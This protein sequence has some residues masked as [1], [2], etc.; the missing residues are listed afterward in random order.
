METFPP[1]PCFLLVQNR[2]PLT[3][4][5]PWILFHPSLMKASFVLSPRILPYRPI[6][7]YV[8]GVNHPQARFNYHQTMMA[9]VQQV[10][11][12]EFHHSYFTLP[13]CGA[14]M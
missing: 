5:I 3:I 13:K 4:W 11:P 2:Q 1:Y 7:S 9:P 8:S 6:Y 12:K 10:H 14:I